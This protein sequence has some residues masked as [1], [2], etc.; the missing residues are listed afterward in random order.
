MTRRALDPDTVQAKLDRLDGLVRRLEPRAGST[1]ADLHKDD[2][3]R[4]STL[5][6]LLQLV[7]LGAA[8]GSH[9]AAARLGRTASTYAETFVLLAEA[10][11]ITDDLV[12]ALRGASGMRNVLVH[13]YEEIDLDVVAAALPS[14]VATFTALRRQVAAWLLSLDDAGVNPP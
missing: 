11:A 12:P 6:L 1:A 10:G 4:D 13:Q 3:L 7:T 2:V 5:W 8:V 9:V 14:A